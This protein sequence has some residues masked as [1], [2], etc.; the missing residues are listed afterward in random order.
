MMHAQE[1]TEAYDKMETEHWVSAAALL[2]STTKA[3]ITKKVLLEFP[4]GICC[5]ADHFSNKPSKLKAHDRDNN[6]NTRCV[7]YAWWKV[8]IVGRECA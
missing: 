2:K 5:K 4:G 6:S 8:A 3:C 7:Q 1:T